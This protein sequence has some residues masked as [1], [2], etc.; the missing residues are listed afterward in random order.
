M[1]VFDNKTHEQPLFYLVDK[2]ILPM[3]KEGALESVWFELQKTLWQN[4]KKAKSAT[5]YKVKK[6]FCS[7][8]VAFMINILAIY[9][10]FEAWI[11]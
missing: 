4:P 6:A 8:Y 10:P 7:N 2:L 11:V 1:Y 9:S 5:F 3:Q